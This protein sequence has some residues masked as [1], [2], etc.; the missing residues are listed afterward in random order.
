[1]RHSSARKQGNFPP[2]SITRSPAD[3]THSIIENYKPTL[4][5]FRQ[6]SRQARRSPLGF[7]S[8]DLPQ[9]LLSA[10]VVR[11]PITPLARIWSAQIRNTAAANA[12][13]ED[14]EPDW[15]CAD[16]EEVYTEEDLQVIKDSYAEI[17]AGIRPS[18]LGRVMHRVMTQAAFWT[19]CEEFRPPVRLYHSR[20]PLTTPF[21]FAFYSERAQSS[22][23]QRLP[24]FAPTGAHRRDRGPSIHIYVIALSVLISPST[25]PRF[26]S[27]FRRSQ[28]TRLCR[29]RG[30]CMRTMRR[31]SQSLLKISRPCS[32]RTSVPSVWT[33]YYHCS[34]MLRKGGVVGMPIFVRL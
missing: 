13:L 1:V 16:F 6:L 22:C 23:L 20:A 33:L 17:P 14:P 24:H 7:T 15:T 30:R 28:R 26:M 8:Q 32:G 19:K 5:I 12:L 2:C 21:F 9:R 3:G 29:H 34:N 10:R 31:D 27:N 18:L 25:Q 11:H 4:Y